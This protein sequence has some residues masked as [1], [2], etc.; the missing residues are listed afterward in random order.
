MCAVNEFILQVPS[1]ENP[2][3]R[4][5]AGRFR[6]LLFALLSSPAEALSLRV[7]LLLW[8]QSRS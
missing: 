3:G 1:R 2:D 7:I 6:N 5:C 8:D 4:F